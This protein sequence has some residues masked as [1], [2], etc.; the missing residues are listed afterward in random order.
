MLYIEA[1]EKGV[2]SRSR[3]GESILCIHGNPTC[4]KVKEFA[5]KDGSDKILID[6]RGISMLQKIREHFGKPLIINSGY[7]TETY[8]AKVGGAKNSY[9]KYG[10]AYDIRIKEVTPLEIAKYAEEIGVKGIGWYNTFT[11]VD[12]R[13]KRYFWHN[14]SGNSMTTFH[15]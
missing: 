15:I 14:K 2:Y 11:H 4:F 5:C 8:N 1:T 13:E 12:L 9:H 10:K 3:D 6:K 7:R